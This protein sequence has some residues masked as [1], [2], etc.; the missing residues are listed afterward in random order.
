MLIL[1]GIRGAPGDREFSGEYTRYPDPTKDK[2]SEPAV[3]DLIMA[4]T[5]LLPFI[6]S[7]RC[8]A[9]PFCSDHV[10]VYVVLRVPTAK[11]TLQGM[12]AEG[13]EECSNLEHPLWHVGPF[14]PRKEWGTM[15]EIEA[16]VKD[17]HM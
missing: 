17:F 12:A 7:V 4:D 5:A 10:P 2:G 6:E 3:L 14:L 8:G 15:A 9:L 13:R 16:A 11:A 1:N